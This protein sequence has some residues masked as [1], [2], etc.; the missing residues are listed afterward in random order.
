MFF[1]PTCQA[2]P[3][4]EEHPEALEAEQAEALQEQPEEELQE[5]IPVVAA[6]DGEQ[7]PEG[8]FSKLLAELNAQD[9]GA[10]SS[11]HGVET[12]ELEALVDHWFQDPMVTFQGLFMFGFAF[13][14]CLACMG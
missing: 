2:A 3:A 1:F 9:G 4:E 6:D 8:P 7:E 10:G 5:D 11:Q 14:K 13:F 12:D